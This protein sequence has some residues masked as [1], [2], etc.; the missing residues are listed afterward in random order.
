M[1]TGARAAVL[2]AAPPEEKRRRRPASAWLRSAAQEGL[3]CWERESGLPPEL[4]RGSLRSSGQPGSGVSGPLAA[5]RD[6]GFGKGASWGIK[7]LPPSASSSLEVIWLSASLLL[8]RRVASTFPPSKPSF[9]P[10]S[11]PPAPPAQAPPHRLRP[12]QPPGLGRG[13][14]MLSPA[15]AAAQE[16]ARRPP[17]RRCRKRVTVMQKTRLGLRTR[18]LPRSHRAN[19]RCRG[20]DYSSQPA[21]PP[22]GSCL[23]TTAAGRPRHGLAR[24]PPGG[25]PAAA[26][27]AAGVRL[28][29]RP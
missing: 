8:P 16:E 26:A 17:P 24:R 7:P 9:S 1:D 23:R 20:Q 14:R 5:H 18:L 25:G 12:Q 22:C 2:P 10:P 28:L 29:H 27:A 13:R 3:R 21:P 11:L 4:A 15:R 6:Y 19:G